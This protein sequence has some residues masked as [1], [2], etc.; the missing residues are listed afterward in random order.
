MVVNDNKGFIISNLR[1]HTNLI[2]TK[3]E[4][5]RLVELA[6]KGDEEAREL[7]ITSNSDWLRPLLRTTP[8]LTPSLGK[9]FTKRAHWGC[10]MR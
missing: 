7:L 6:Q 10:L 3:E 5:Y 1:E 9:I 8:S 2:E 4:E